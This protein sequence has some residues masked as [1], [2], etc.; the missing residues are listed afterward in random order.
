M[1]VTKIN[2]KTR[3]REKVSGVELCR[4]MSAPQNAETGCPLDVIVPARAGY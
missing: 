1:R 3:T 4:P 2:A